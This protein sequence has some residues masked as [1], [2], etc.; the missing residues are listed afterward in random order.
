MRTYGLIGKTLTHSFSKRYFEE[1]YRF[2]LDPS[3]SRYLNF[4]LSSIDQ[5]MDLIHAT[6]ELVGF[7]VTVPY[8]STVMPFIHELSFDASAIGAVNVVRIEKNLDSSEGPILHGFNTDHL[9]FTHA[10][11]PLLKPHHQRALVI[12]NG[13]AAASVRYALTTMGIAFHSTCRNPQTAEEFHFEELDATR[14]GQYQIL[15]NTTPVG[16]WPEV[17]AMP[18]IPLNGIDDRHLVFDLVYNPEET[19]LMQQAKTQGATTS[20]GLIMLR[21]QADLSLEIWQSP[22][23]TIHQTFKQI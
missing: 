8:K 19:K 6:P 23:S 13:G 17:D 1:K 14:V 15:I 4:E 7:N 12:G 18:P 2:N 3:A 5:L 20:N 22:I 21:K 16:T 11:K 9:G 10:I